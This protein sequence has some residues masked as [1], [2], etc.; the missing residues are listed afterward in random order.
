MC[1]FASHI[2]NN[3]VGVCLGGGRKGYWC[4]STIET[5]LVNM[6]L[7]FIPGTV[8]NRLDGKETTAVPCGFQTSVTFPSSW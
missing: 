8:W 4:V 7:V 1:V 5:R 3:A 2:V 6:V